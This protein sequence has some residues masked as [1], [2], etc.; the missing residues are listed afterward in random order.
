MKQL[1]DIY[2]GKIYAEENV[3]KA[4]PCSKKK[5]TITFFTLSRYVTC[6][7]LEQEYKSRGLAP[8]DLCTLAAYMEVHKD[9]DLRATQWKDKDDKYY[10]ATF[11]VWD[12]ERHVNVYRNVHVWDGIWS[13]G[14]VPEVASELIPSENP[15]DSLPLTL[16]INGFTYRRV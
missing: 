12:D 2:T 10:C 16:E 9:E 11:Y 13:F 15:L 3:L 7:E 14:G 4:A 1:K 5:Q 8:V 6:T